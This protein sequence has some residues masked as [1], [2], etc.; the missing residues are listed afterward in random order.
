MPL[1]EMIDSAQQQGI[2]V[3]TEV[4]PYTA[5]STF[6]GAAIF[7]GDFTRRLGLAYGDISSHLHRAGPALGGYRARAGERRFRGA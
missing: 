3:T 4:Y 7:D 5:W 2:D 1:L 6:I